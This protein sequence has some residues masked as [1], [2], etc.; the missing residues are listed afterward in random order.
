MDTFTLHE[1][2]IFRKVFF[3][4]FEQNCSFLRIFPN[5]LKESLME[6]I[7]SAMISIYVCWFL[8]V[9]QWSFLR[10]SPYSVRIQENKVQKNSV[11]ELF[12]R[13]ASS[14]RSS[15]STNLSFTEYMTFLRNWLFLTLPGSFAVIPQ[16]RN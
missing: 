4:K 16:T 13:A 14:S 2:D 12:S 7:F 1:S 9:I 15:S 5:L 11:F 6:N 8:V 3:S 10:N